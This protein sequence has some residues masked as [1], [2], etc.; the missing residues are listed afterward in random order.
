M[1]TVPGDQPDVLRDLR[2]ANDASGGVFRHT[3]R[4]LMVFDAD[5]A[6]RVNR[7]NYADLTL[8]DRFLDLVRGRS[9]TRVDWRQ[10]RSLWLAR[11][12]TLAGPA[13]LRALDERM[14]AV[15]RERLDVPLRLTWL[16]HEISFRA[17][18]PVIVDGL[19][20]VDRARLHEDAIAKIARLMGEQDEEPPWW[21][22]WRPL[23]IQ[24]NAGLVV[25]REVRRRARRRVPPREDLTEPIATELLAA[26]GGD[27]AV[28]AI[29]AVLT[30]VA[31]PPGASAACVLYELVRRPDWAARIA[32]EFAPASPDDVYDSG[33]R[34]APLTHRF[35]KEVLRMWTSP[36][37]LTRSARTELTIGDYQVPAGQFFVVSPAMVHHD[38]RH[39]RDPEVFDPDRW[40]PDAPNGP[41]GAAHYVPFGWPPTACVGAGLGM[42]QLVLLCR[43]FTTRYRIM[44]DDPDALRMSIGPVP[45]PI[46]FTGR[47]T[48]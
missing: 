13:G 27:R 37:M 41:A 45:L 22:S 19:S 26:L 48:R 29:T 20:T 39:W 7:D 5:A 16:A 46:G 36:T 40:L 44:V 1:T 3:D 4:Q 31:G 35:V 6:M 47:V 33:T 8:P 2:A 10:V 24:V 17:L 28:D 23:S 9:S 21:R 38:P 25:R 12:R 32:E 43:L 15:L 30:A 34:I 14:A 11:L 42:A 18:L